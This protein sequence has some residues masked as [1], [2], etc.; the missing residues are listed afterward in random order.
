MRLPS[1]REWLTALPET[2]A[3]TILVEG[4]PEAEGFRVQFD[5][6][7][8]AHARTHLSGVNYRSDS[9]VRKFFNDQLGSNKA[10]VIISKAGFCLVLAAG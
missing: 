10:T 1:G 7:Q 2:R 8:A 4:L 5:T 9:A 6:I 3:K